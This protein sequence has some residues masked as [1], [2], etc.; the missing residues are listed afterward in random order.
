MPDWTLSVGGAGRVGSGVAALDVVVNK[1]L[2][3][4]LI[5]VIDPG[6]QDGYLE[7]LVARFMWFATHDDAFAFESALVGLGQDQS[8]AHLCHERNRLHRVAQD[9]IRA[10]VVN[11]IEYTFA[12]FVYDD[13][14]AS[15]ASRMT[16]SF[17]TVVLHAAAPHVA[18]VSNTMVES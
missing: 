7:V 16:P 13:R 2:D 1:G 9:A 18:Q 5:F 4:L 3:G 12:G 8:D 6:K 11:V 17:S 15:P 14:K 10:D